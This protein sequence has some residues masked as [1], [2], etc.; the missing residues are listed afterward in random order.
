[1]RAELYDNFFQHV[2]VQISKRKLL[3]NH[4]STTALLGGSFIMC[5]HIFIFLFELNNY[6]APFFFFYYYYYFFLEQL[7]SH[8]NI[9]VIK[10]RRFAQDIQLVSF[11][12]VFRHIF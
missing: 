3:L 4:D 11:H 9:L 12:F 8:L 1:M 10:P 5:S 7:L 6:I 2:K